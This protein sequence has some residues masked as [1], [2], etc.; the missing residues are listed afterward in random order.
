[1]KACDAENLRRLVSYDSDS[2]GI[3]DYGDMTAVSGGR[4]VPLSCS[5]GLNWV[6]RNGACGS[7]GGEIYLLG[8]CPG[9][10]LRFVGGSYLRCQR[11]P[12]IDHQ[13]GA[14][15]ECSH[16]DHDKRCDLPIFAS[17]STFE[18]SFVAL[19]GLSTHELTLRN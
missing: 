8:S 6:E 1:M 12:A 9:R 4:Q 7:V 10:R 13:T 16:H 19:K 17:T 2:D 11:Q 15:D 18:F 3:A 5:I 14:E